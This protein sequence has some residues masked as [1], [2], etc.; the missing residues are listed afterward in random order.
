MTTH[1]ALFLYTIFMFLESMWGTGHLA[2]ANN[3]NNFGEEGVPKGNNTN[4]K[5]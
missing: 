2:E 1:C 5:G 3:K 4:N